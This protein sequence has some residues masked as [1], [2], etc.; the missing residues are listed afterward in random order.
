MNYD[1]LSGIRFMLGL[2][3]YI[4]LGAVALASVKISVTEPDG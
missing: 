2:I 3:R 4:G 1:S